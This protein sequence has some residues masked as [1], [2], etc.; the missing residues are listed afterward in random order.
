MAQQSE[1]SSANSVEG[2]GGQSGH[3]IDDE[4]GSTH[5]TKEESWD[6]REV[7]EMVDERENWRVIG[8]SNVGNTCFTNAILQVFSYFPCLPY[9]VYLSCTDACRQ[10]EVLGE[11]FVR[12]SEYILPPI[13]TTHLSTDFTSRSSRS[14]TRRSEVIQED[15]PAPATKYPSVLR[16]T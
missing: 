1:V 14:K 7:S 3:E 5:E 10:T 11:Y 9:L 12:R 13:T 6:D 16:D 8:L 2:K 15:E 4:Y